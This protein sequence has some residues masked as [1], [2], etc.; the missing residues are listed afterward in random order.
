MS[1]NIAKQYS[2]LLKLILFYPGTKMQVKL[3]SR[4]NYNYS[5]NSIPKYTLNHNPWLMLL[6]ILGKIIEL[7]EFF[8]NQ[9]MSNLTS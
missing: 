1:F 2:Q 9:V 4:C 6:L 7:T 5:L 3:S 8:V